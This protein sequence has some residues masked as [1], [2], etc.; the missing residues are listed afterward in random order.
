MIRIYVGVRLRLA[1][2]VA[3]CDDVSIHVLYP[4]H[5][6]GPWITVLSDLFLLE[7]LLSLRSLKL[8]VHMLA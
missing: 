4:L 8:V 6:G 5:I 7:W 2:F 3:D 1:A